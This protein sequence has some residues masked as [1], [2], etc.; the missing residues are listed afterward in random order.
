M[1]TSQCI[2]RG[3]FTSV[4]DLIRRIDSYI[5]SYNQHATPFTWTHRETR[6]RIHVPLSSLS[7]H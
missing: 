7:R 5:Q 2:R 1:I 3:T 6:K 4:R